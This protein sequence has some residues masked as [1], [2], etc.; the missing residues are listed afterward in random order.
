VFFFFFL[1]VAA[2]LQTMK[3]THEMKSCATLL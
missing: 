1:K 3:L 2:H